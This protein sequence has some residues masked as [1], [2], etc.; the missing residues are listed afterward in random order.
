MIIPSIQFCEQ[1]FDEAAAFDR[2]DNIVNIYNTPALFG[3]ITYILSGAFYE[4]KEYF[5]KRNLP[6]I[7][8]G[9][10]EDGITLP[11]VNADISAIV[12][13][14]TELFDKTNAYPVTYIT[15]PPVGEHFYYLRAFEELNKK[16]G[17][18]NGKVSTFRLSYTDEIYKAQLR[19]LLNQGNPPRTIIAPG[20]IEAL[21]VIKIAQQLGIKIPEQLQIICLDMCTTPSNN[22][23]AITGYSRDFVE[24]GTHLAELI[25]DIRNKAD[26]A[27]KH[28]LSKPVLVFRDTFIHS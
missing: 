18:S 7:V 20:Y 5:Q 4:M 19:Q 27:N 17:K 28:I 25:R 24:V 13:E 10:A 26:I 9:A 22:T 2:I 23:P 14:L 15:F 21:D 8:L 12:L 11:T 6:A 1:W 3:K 16:P